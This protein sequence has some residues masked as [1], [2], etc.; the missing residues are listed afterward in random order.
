MGVCSR[1]GADL[2]ARGHDVRPHTADAVIEAWAQTAAGCYEE[3]VAAFV[4]IFVDTRR[5]R[6]GEIV[7]FDVGPA[8][9]EDLLVLLLERV[10]LYIDAGGRVPI[11]TQ[12][13]LCGD[14]LAA[15]LALAA[16][17]TDDV[18]GSTPKGVPYHDLTFG[19]RDGGWHCR[20][21]I[22]V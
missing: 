3:A 11:A 8:A 15:H 7:T 17:A 9:P 18:I 19:P 13:R 20:A 21:T 2:A 14:R 12:V 16:P 10:L 5:A 4:D 1:C 22:D 6:A